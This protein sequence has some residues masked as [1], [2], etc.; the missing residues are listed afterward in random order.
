[1]DLE[2]NLR[3]A[4]MFIAI[5]VASSCVSSNKIEASRSVVC[6]AFCKYK[7]SNGAFGRLWF[8][9]VNVE[10]KKAWQQLEQ[11]CQEISCQGCAYEL[12]VSM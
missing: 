1:M 11:T 3:V 8:S 4:M 2:V 9:Q 7:T 10:A 12:Q 5:F 6:S